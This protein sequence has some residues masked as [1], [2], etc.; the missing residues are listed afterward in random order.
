MPQLP[1]LSELMVGAHLLGLR[2]NGPLLRSAPP[3]RSKASPRHAETYMVPLP[4]RRGLNPQLPLLMPAM[5]DPPPYALLP[6]SADPGAHDVPHEPPH[7]D[8]SAGP[9]GAR[10]HAWNAT[11]VLPKQPGPLRAPP[12][13]AASHPHDN[14]RNYRHH[15]HPLYTLYQL[16]GSQLLLPDAAQQ[17]AFGSLEC[18]ASPAG[19]AAA[20]SPSTYLQPRPALFSHAP[21][22]GPPQ[23]AYST[24]MGPV[25]LPQAFSPYGAIAAAPPHAGPHPPGASSVHAGLV[26]YAYGFQPLGQAVFL[27]YG[28]PFSPYGPVV[29][30][31]GQV[32][33]QLERPPRDGS[34]ER[35]N[36]LLNHRRVI[37]RRTRT[38]CLTCRKRR[39]KCDERKPHCFNC[40][41]SKKLC[42]GYEV[43]PAA[44]KRRDAEE[45]LAKKPEHRLSVHDL[46]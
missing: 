7:E 10:A 22:Q 31:A 35:N 27:H 4:P 2:E 26:P 45:E 11:S 39:I 8:A 32:P 34:A 21:A 9:A 24:P 15:T 17:P 30:G 6:R 38:G 23:F 41:R 36:A 33:A 16:A 20:D 12:A 1:S 29:V 37:K 46:L 18:V 5:R 40:E 13:Y 14:H 19:A 25:V 28:M 42:L 44:G 43:L 3:A